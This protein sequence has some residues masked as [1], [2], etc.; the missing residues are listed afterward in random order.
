MDRR[1]ALKNIGLTTG[2]VIASPAL[3]NFLQSCATEDPN[4]WKPTFMS[5]D[6]ALVLENLVDTFIPKTE[7][8]PSASEVNAV[9]FI[10]TYWNEVSTV[11]YQ[12]K[13]KAAFA[14]VIEQLKATYNEDLNKLTPE[15]YMAYLDANMVHPD[16]EEPDPPG[17]N[18][19]FE[20]T[21]DDRP[22]K[23]SKF[24]G[25]LKWMS[26]NAFL[27]SEEVGENV[28]VYDPVPGQYI[29]DDLQTLTGGKKYSL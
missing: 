15:N 17:V 20:L 13:V 2:F 19:G 16:D 26:I 3:F 14:K 28:L 24:L 5:Q 4:A 1:Q 21:E 8:S 25:G 7:D 18:N 10:D 22:I 11:K 23:L 6:E 12:A 27:N 9:V 29:C